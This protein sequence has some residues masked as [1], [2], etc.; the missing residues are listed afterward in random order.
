MGSPDSRRPG[1]GLRARPCAPQQDS[2]PSHDS[3]VCP[4]SILLASNKARPH[5][6]LFIADSKVSCKA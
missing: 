3:G 6:P 2:S 1:R 5:K 4:L